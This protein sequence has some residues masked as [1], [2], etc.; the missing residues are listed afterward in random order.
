MIEATARLEVV[1]QGARTI[2]TAY[3]KDTGRAPEFRQG[4]H[5]VAGRL[6]LCAER[7]PKG[8]GKDVVRNHLPGSRVMTIFQLSVSRQ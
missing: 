5:G 3:G 7:G 2:Q 4:R 6:W 1:R 8:Y